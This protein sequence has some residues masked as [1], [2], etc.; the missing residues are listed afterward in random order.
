MRTI[1][2]YL[3]FDGNCREAMT[4]YQE[5][6]GGDLVMM[7]VAES[8]M[9]DQWP[10][11][12]QQQVLHASLTNENLVLLGSDMGSPEGPIEGNTVMLS[13]TCRTPEEVDELYDKLAA[14]GLRLREPHD[15]FAGR[16]SALTDKFGK[17]WIINAG[18]SQNA[19]FSE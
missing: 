3:V 5:C 1:N 4:F 19:D 11:A 15:F 7:T 13:L 12:M 14:G 6:L 8:P 16:M 18:S 10:A 2:V 9:A 17:G